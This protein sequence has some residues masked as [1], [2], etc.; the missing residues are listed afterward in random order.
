MNKSEMLKIVRN[1]LS[2]DMNCNVDDFSKDGIVFCRAKSNQG[3]RMIHRQSPFLEIATMGKSIIVSADNNI[4]PKAKQLLE[5]KS[6]EDI[7]VAPFLFGHSLCYIP[8]VDRIKNLPCPEGFTFHVKEGEKVYELYKTLGFENAIQYEMNNY[9]PDVIAM[10]AMR[11]N[12]IVAMAGASAD[13][14]TMWQ[15]GID[16]LPKYRNKGLATNLVSNLAIK[17]M[18]KGILPYYCAASSNIA[19]QS[20]AY[21][22]GF[23]ITWM[24]SYKNIFD[25]TAPYEHEIKINF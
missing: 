4:L 17:I 3:R 19:S 18:E 21:K 1:Q 9:G 16:V 8:D 10:Y 11:N 25:G 2:I 12:E 20:V 7:F 14:S 6:R 5:N 13:S 23:M 15:I 24:C 22:S